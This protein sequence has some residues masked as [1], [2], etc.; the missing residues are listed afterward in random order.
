METSD[1]LIQ[2]TTQYVISVLNYQKCYHFMS[3]I[4]V[5]TLIGACFWCETSKEIINEQ[6]YTLIA[7]RE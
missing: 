3:S 7:V 4:P 6:M 5:C 1:N 2:T